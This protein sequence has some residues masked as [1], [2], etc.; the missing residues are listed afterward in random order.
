[1]RNIPASKVLQLLPP[2]FAAVWIILSVTSVAGHA[3]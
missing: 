3:Q 2:T 1:M